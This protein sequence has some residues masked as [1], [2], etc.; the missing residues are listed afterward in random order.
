MQSS[1]GIQR[2]FGLSDAEAEIVAR[3]RRGVALWRVAG[4]P[5][6]VE[7]RLSPTERA[8]VDTDAALVT[9]GGAHS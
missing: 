6:L 7:H 1:A 2:L 4:R 5:F 9:E 8:V 3:L